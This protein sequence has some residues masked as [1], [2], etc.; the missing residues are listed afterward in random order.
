MY[1]G[2]VEFDIL[3]EESKV[4]LRNKRQGFM[5]FIQVMKVDEDCQKSTERI[6]EQR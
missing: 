2:F 1:R 5:L 4:L 6:Q 3:E